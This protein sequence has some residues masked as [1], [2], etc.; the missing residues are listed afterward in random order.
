MTERCYIP[1]ACG[2]HDVLEALAT[3]RQPCEIVYRDAAYQTVQARATIQ[4]VYAA[5]RVEYLK[6]DSGTIIRLD[7]LMR[8]NDQ[9]F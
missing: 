6:L 7:D 9:E 1:I 4:D 5:D 2:L 3:L 8:V